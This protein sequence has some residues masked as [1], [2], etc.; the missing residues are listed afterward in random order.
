MREPAAAAAAADPA[1]AL[2]VSRAPEECP[3]CGTELD[4]EEEAACKERASKPEA[5]YGEDE[6]EE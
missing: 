1:A 5:P 4:E 2:L 3:L 6:E